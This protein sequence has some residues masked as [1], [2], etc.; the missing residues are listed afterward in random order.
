MSPYPQDRGVTVFVGLTVV[1][2][3]GEDSRDKRPL[4]GALFRETT[5]R[6]TQWVLLYLYGFSDSFGGVISPTQ[7]SGWTI[8]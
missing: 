4:R 5:F 7:P 1:Q 2:V 8:K 6:A 3:A